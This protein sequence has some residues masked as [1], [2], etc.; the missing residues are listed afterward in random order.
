MKR[1]TMRLL[2][3]AAALLLA[4]AAC[5]EDAGALLAR[6]KAAS[7]GARWDAVQAIASRGTLR[8]GGLSGPIATLEDLRGG[9]HA[10]RYTLGRLEGADGYD[11]RTA[12]EQDPGGEVARLD[13]AEAM[14]R[15]RTEAWLTARAYWY[16]QRGAARYGAVTTREADGRRYAVVEATPE[17]GA[18]VALWFDAASGLLART[19][20]KVGQNVLTVR[21]EDWRA[22]DGVRL[23]FR[24]VSDRGDPRS[25]VEVALTQARLDPALHEADFAMPQAPASRARIA[26]AAAVTRVPFELVNNHIYVRAEV[27]GK[28]VRLLVDTGGFNLLTPAAAKRLGLAAEGKLLAQGVG[29]KG[30]D[31]AL[32]PARSLRVGDAVLERPVMYVIDLGALGAVEGLDFD[33][34]VGFEM[35]S[36]FGVRIDY[37]QRELVL[38]EP[39]K[40]A[41]PAGARAIPFTL[42]ERIPVIAGTLDGTPLRI[43]VDTGSRASLTFHGPFARAHGLA[44]RYGAAPESVVGWGVGGPSYGRPLR[45]GTLDLGG[46]DVPGIAADI[47]TGTKGSFA[48]PDLDANL[49]GGVLKR[50]TVAF[51]YAQRRMY[52]A[53]NADFARPDLYDRSGLWLLGDGA[54]LRVGAVAPQSAAARAGLRADDRLLAIDGVAV[55][56]R[57]L[58]AW[59]QR[60]REL[61][62]GTR[63]AVRYARD[64][65]AAELTLTLA[66][67]IPPP[68]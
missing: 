9:R 52:L 40:F 57:T 35:F 49:G 17:G 56:T 48:N 1:T 61:P 63:L 58:A 62:A 47:F 29:E 23:P 21:Y 46:I 32:A 51:D 42:E 18:A 37:A 66:D 2:A 12:W 28:P 50:F 3:A 54:A 41:P 6:Y 22:V 8:A 34:L 53:P 24:S 14:A 16:P 25:R 10:S 68:R 11:G 30:G 5:A 33:G 19:T 26:N 39:A 67:Q 64:G 55:A 27:D 13:G 20:Q 7:G 15:A 43:S 38:S 44:E 4:A 65:R 45:L 59:R 60:L 36:R 31:V